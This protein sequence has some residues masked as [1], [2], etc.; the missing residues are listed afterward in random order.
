MR[1]AA[2]RSDVKFEV[3][4]SDCEEVRGKDGM[5]VKMFAAKTLPKEASSIRFSIRR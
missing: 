4:Q 3:R 1:I 2:E 5:A